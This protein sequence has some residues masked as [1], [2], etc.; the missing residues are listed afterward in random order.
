MEPTSNAGKRP[1]RVRQWL[2][3]RF[4]TEQFTFRQIWDMFVPLIFDQL[5]IYGIGILSVS[6]VSSSGQ[7]AMAAVS[8]V[9]S[10]GFLVT[11]VFSSLATGGAI[12]V[13]RAVGS[14]D[15]NRVRRATAQTV[16]LTTLTSAV[17][18]AVFVVFA[19]PLVL[20]LFPQADPLVRTY[21]VE[22]LRTM[23]LS[24]VPFAVFNSIFYVFRGLGDSRSSLVLTIIINGTHLLCTFW[25]VN[26]LGMGVTGSALSYVVARSIGA[27]TA[28]VWL[29]KVNNRVHVRVRDLF[30]LSRDV[31][32]PVVQLGL[33][34]ALEQVLFQA[35]AVLA[36]TYIS[37]LSVATIAANGVAN[38]SFNLFLATAFALMNTA[39][40]ICGQCVGARR[41]DLVRQYIRSFV[42]AGRFVLAATVLL[43]APII[44]LVL[45][46]Y[47]PTAEALPLIY[48][49]LCIGVVPLPFLW[50]DS[51]IIPA[52]IRTAG[53]VT[54]TTIVSLCAMWFS[55]VGVGYVLAIPCG[56]GIA[57]VWLGIVTEWLIRSVIWHIR[58]RGDKWIK[59]K[60]ESTEE[61][62]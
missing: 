57:G 60:P 47:S 61:K 44:P 41:F 20:A 37:S 45:R 13:A 27:V 23:S 12:I 21:A 1:G 26:G 17:C 39:T 3:R 33:P 22:Y 62:A 19:Q 7:E 35:G 59:L 53:D 30:H 36:A 40:T 31:V 28:V 42:S 48:T 32:A 5:F 29:F 8:M 25:F 46:L 9:G 52:S 10:L 16:S 6:M 54:F 50:A 43:V 11:A 55:R 38:S 18:T 56:L 15:Q 58:M 2:E 14:G 34:L 4:T 49:A 51:N 24:Y